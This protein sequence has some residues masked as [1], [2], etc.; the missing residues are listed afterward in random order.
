M[1]RRTTPASTRLGGGDL[2]SQAD[3]ERI[4][5]TP[6]T[7][8]ENDPRQKGYWNKSNSPLIICQLFFPSFFSNGFPPRVLPF[9][10]NVLE[11]AS[12]V[13][14]DHLENKDLAPPGVDASATKVGSLPQH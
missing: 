3:A 10:A 7:A 11:L 12:L 2:E 8:S 13:V 1:N 5:L 6:H 14:A 4:D 9:L